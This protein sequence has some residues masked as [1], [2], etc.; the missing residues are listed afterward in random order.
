MR[1]QTIRFAIAVATFFVGLAATNAFNLVYFG[2]AADG[3]AEQEVLKVE[4]TYIRAHLERDVAAL[5]SVLADDFTSF[6]GRV[7]KEH[8]LALLSNP[9]FN[10][11]SL[12]TED[13]S[14]KVE[15]NEARVSGSARM[16][17]DFRGRE[18]NTPRY[19]FTRRYE[20]REGRWQI[21]SCE[22]TFAGWPAEY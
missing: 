20:L 19:G 11:T 12:V 10:V 14:V 9:L 6:R 22:F 16:T 15:G 2:S 1:H 5:E 17:G 21:V 3:S 7:R 18:I 4:R 13:V 8:R